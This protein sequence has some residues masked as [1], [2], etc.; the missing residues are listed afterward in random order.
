M[1]ADLLIDDLM[2][3]DEPKSGQLMIAYAPT[4]E[5]EVYENPPRFSWIPVI[6]AD[7]RYVLRV[8]VDPEFDASATMLFEDIEI[9]FFTPDR[10]FEPGRYFWQY[11]V[12]NAATGQ[13]ASTW[14][15][16]RSFD[17]AEGLA[18]PVLPTRAR[19]YENVDLAR[20]RLWLGP[21][22]LKA[23]AKDV[24]KNPEH[25][26]WS[27]FYD[28]SVL[29]WLD[30]KIIQELPP[31]PGNVRVSDVWRANYILC[32]EV[33][34]AIRHLAI[35][36]RVLGDEKLLDRAKDW[37]LA[38]AAWNPKGTTSHAYTD[39]WAFR[40][41]SALAWGYDWLYDHLTEA[42]RETVRTALSTRAEEIADHVRYRA[43]IHLF[44]Y[45]SH[46][47]R[48][49]S[50]ALTP[51]CIALL[52][53]EPKAKVWL[54]H[55]LDFLFTVYSPWGG[56]D[57][58]WAEGPHYW[59][60]GMA[61]L[62]EAAN[63]IRSFTK[64]DLYQRPFFQK[65]GD[66]PLYTK[67]PGT[68]RA[69]FGDD[70]TLGD[71][72]CLKVGYNLRQFAGVTGNGHYQWYF[73]EVKRQDPGTEMA[74]YNYGWWDLNFDELVYR[75]DF[76][77]VEAKPPSD[78]PRLKWFR[79]VGW[80]AI[81]LHMDDPTKHIQFLLKSSPYGSVSHSHG[82]QC[83]FQ[84]SAFGEDL[85]IQSGYYVA[86]NSSM[87]RDWRRQTRSKNAVLI[88]GKGQY[89]GADK[90]RAMQAKGEI[91]EAEERD[92]HIYLR[93]DATPAYA[94]ANAD[95]TRYEREVYFI[96]DSYAVIIDRIEATRG[97]TVDWLIHA[98]GL[99]EFGGDSFRYTGEKAGFYG[100]F[101]YSSSGRPELSQ[102]EG[103]SGVDPAEFEDL[104]KSCHLE[105]RFP[106]ANE[107][108]IATLLV[109]YPKSAPKRLFQFIDDQ[110]Y[111][112]NLY[113][114][115]SD[116]QQFKIVIPKSFGVT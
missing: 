57:G 95:V 12:W 59:M 101:V 70:S 74:F 61:Y 67:V 46:A 26:G 63:L 51:A 42:E 106:E 90:V 3:L 96:R 84:M 21:D 66:F 35:A 9:N 114:T 80:A 71:L 29:P 11:A 31:Y 83:A 2:P 99:M 82:D 7:A 39:E 34:Y 98:S 45:D 109:P 1:S 64:L 69:C 4:G 55:T 104:A 25:C 60:T 110:G 93:A 50:A 37:L 49:L 36:G 19:R 10:A 72:P 56:K 85:A 87:H 44:P 73:D 92:D 62:T 102:E 78:L 91:L 13:P 81:Q 89:A 113:I 40:I 111:T 23:L 28:K 97:V 52:G 47:V 15:T 112:A 30:R 116:D 16:V 48:A 43:N 88:D 38:V 65:T 94:A 108:I 58:G 8:S 103:F 27:T 24:K 33:I 105:A 32:Q 6:D 20:P 79:D 75:H 5:S 76:R 41:T 86:F 14:S 68:R 53:D 17:L 100:Q 115:D 107:H 77:E 18:G 54:D 22:A